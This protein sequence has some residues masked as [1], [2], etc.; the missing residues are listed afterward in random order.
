MT[1][2]I[3]RLLSLA[4]AVVMCI[5]ASGCGAFSQ[6]E[7]LVYMNYS[8][9]MDEFG[10]YDS[11]LF[12]K[13]GQTDPDGADPGVFY[14]SVEE[15]PEWGGYFYRYTTSE[16]T[17]FPSDGYYQENGTKV[18]IAYC[19]RSK[20]LYH[21]ETAGAL[22]G[23]Y[24]CG[25]DALDWCGS[26]FWAPEVIR[27]PGDGKY[28]MYFSAAANQGLGVDYISNSDNK[29]DRFYLGV[30]VSDTP[31][32]PFDVIC[33]IDQTTGRRVPTINFQ[34]GFDLEYNIGAIDAHAF[35]DDDGQLYLYYVRHPDE[36]Y[37]KGNAIC[38]MKM[39]S[40]AYPDY[41]TAVVLTAPGKKTVS[42][43]PGDALRFE[44]GEDYFT[45]ES[46]VN[47][48]PF[49]YKHNG[50]YYLTYSSNGYDHISY[51]VHQALG[52]S[53]LGP[54]TKLEQAE[55]NPVLDGS[56]FGDVH[57]TA[58]HAFVENGDELWIV[59]HRHSSIYD[60]VGWSR[61]SAV[62]RVNF[63]KNADGVDVLTANGPSRTLTW[64]PEHISGYQNL[65]QT[66]QVTASNGSGTQYLVDE[67]LPLYEVASNYK[68]TAD[69]GD[70]TIT[71][72]WQQPVSVSSIMI[73]NAATPEKGFSKV[74]DV[75]FK[76]AQKPE[77]AAGDYDWA[78]IKDIPLQKDGWDPVSED[79]LECAPAVAEFDAIM[80][81]EIQ[82]TIAED[83]RLL[84]YNKQGDVNTAVDIGEIVVLGGGVTNE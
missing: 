47:E 27:N 72:K 4:L 29:H 46:S 63:V 50:T 11:D 21:W 81:T 49:M 15:D 12:G 74:S 54:F 35:F 44:T 22:A 37:S 13:N 25:V 77:W 59:Y 40:M 70:V 52:D 55:G 38:G 48:G 67:V 7:A 32:G 53:P 58:H 83:D 69:K 39:K 34:T 6:D 79:Y 26:D 73:Y 43:T 68:L 28:Y 2:K 56:L 84:Q 78:V 30:A 33:D 71:L 51:S 65:A 8:T 41:S 31:A 20:D 76:L 66:A 62:D 57:G 3:K 82:I 24:A 5:G 60:G 10:R 14:V 19:D 42:S 36:N 18:L 1:T 9:G 75:R 64:L 45:A 17:S 61:P 80:V 16:T 23:G